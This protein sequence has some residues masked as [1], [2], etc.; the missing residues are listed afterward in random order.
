[1]KKLVSDFAQPR[2]SAL[3]RR[4]LMQGA[5]A[6]GLASLSEATGAHAAVARAAAQD[7]SGPGPA[8]E[9]LIFSAFNVDQAP[10]EI[11]QDAM[12]LYLYG[13]RAAG[14]EELTDTE[15]VRLIQAPASTLSMVLNPAPAREGELNP[16]AIREIRQA[17]QYLVDREFIANDIYAGRAVPMVSH[18]SPLDYDELTVFETVRRSGIRFDPEFANALIAEQMQNAGAALDGAFWTFEGRPVQLKIV[19]RVE[20]ER[21]EIGD[22]FRAALEGAGF[23]VQPIY[24][25]F[26]PATLAVYASDPITFQWHAYTEGWSRSAPDRYDFGTINQMTAPW[27]GYM[28]GWLETGFWQYENEAID[29]IGQQLYRGEFGSKE[30]RDDLYREMTAMGLD[31]SVRLWLATALQTFPAREE[32][33]NLNIDIVGGP[34]S[35]LSLREASVPDSDEIRVGNLWVWTDRTVWNPVAGF[36]DAYSSDIYKNLVDAPVINHPFSGLPIP[37]RATFETETAGPDGTLDV[38]E[39]AVLWDAVADAWTPVGAGVTAVSKV[40]YDYSQYFQAP[41]HH[42]AQITPADLIYAIAQSWEM[43]YDE[44][45]IQIETALGITARPFL[46]TFKGFRLLADDRLETYVDFW[47]FEPDYIASYATVGG[48]STP[49]ELLYAMDEVVFQERRGAYS[50]T[51]AARFSVPWL[52]LVTETDARLIIRTMRRL[53][54]DSAF[55]EAIFNLNGRNLVTA[56]E[57]NARYQACLDWFD[58][59]NLLVISNGPFFLTRYDPPAQFAQA[60]AFRAEGY[61]FQPGDWAFGEPPVLS[62]SVEPPPPALLGDSVS[63]PVSVEGPGALSL[64]Y[65]LI[66]PSAADAASSVVASGEATGTDGSFTV[67][68]GSDVTGALFPSVYQLFLLASSDELAR[69]T[70]RAV[71]LPIGV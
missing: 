48:V 65:V 45:R 39:D 17:A 70:E 42:G 19:I 50:D 44:N 20:D 51:A 49:W 16:F 14:A 5:A 64:R 59:T 66:D 31:E 13:L 9:R 28:P 18:V 11:T 41:F 32:L 22:L 15:G 7:A 4:R 60:D 38:P 47:H 40:T 24:Q 43:A 55:P 1:M 27:L 33:E 58:Q 21:R 10:L 53:Q 57:A 35:A 56:E 6:L 23:Q 3:S 34:K 52:S 46:E 54:G 61:P 29:T 63:V 30:E 69:V 37:F 71:D 36:G 25:P 68:I 12:D 62:V 2:T 26:G 8:T 67:E